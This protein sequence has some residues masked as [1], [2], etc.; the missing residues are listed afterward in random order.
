MPQ[1]SRRQVLQ[2]VGSTSLATLASIPGSGCKQEPQASASNIDP[3]LYLIF[4]GAWVFYFGDKTLTATTVHCSD[5]GYD[6]GVSWPDAQPRMMLGKDHTYTVTVKGSYN[7][8]PPVGMLLKP[9]LDSGEGLILNGNRC[10]PTIPAGGRTVCLPLPSSISQAGLISPVTINVDPM[11]LQKPVKKW[12]AALVLVYSGNWDRAIIESCDDTEP[13]VSIKAG[14]LKYSH[15]SFRTYVASEA[16][17][18]PDCKVDCA[19]LNRAIAHASDVIRA[20]MT[21]ILGLQNPPQNPVG[22]P[23]CS[24]AAAGQ[25]DNWQVLIERGPNTNIEYP[26]IGMPETPCKKFANLHNCAAGTMIVGT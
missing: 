1:F 14:D 19:K 25:S 18:E 24:S 21:D 16:N 17:E 2:A 10:K 23:S 6:M 22:F 13:T 12:P 8:A 9:L 26:E 20:S 5:H 3:S 4:A 15:L 7:P 11:L